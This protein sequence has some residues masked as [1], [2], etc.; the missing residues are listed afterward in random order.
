MNKTKTFYQPY[1]YTDDGTNI[2]YG[3]MP[4]ELMSFQAFASI[5]DCEEW[6]DNN[7]YDHTDFA[8]IE[9]HDEEIEDVTIIDAYGDI[10]EINEYDNRD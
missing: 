8:I 4:D 2:E 5:E 7:G 10:V 3:S 9:Y 1:A 6:L